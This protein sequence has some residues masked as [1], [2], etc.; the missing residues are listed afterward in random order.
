M[1]T[2]NAKHTGLKWEVIFLFFFRQEPGINHQ[3]LQWR[4]AVYSFRNCCFHE[5][6]LTNGTTSQVCGGQG[7]AKVRPKLRYIH[8]FDLLNS[9]KLWKYL[10]RSSMMNHTFLMRNNSDDNCSC[11][12][13]PQLAAVGWLT[14]NSWRQNYQPQPANTSSKLLTSKYE[15]RKFKA[16]YYIVFRL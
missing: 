5:L 12:I 1:L 2:S 9:V 4:H 16:A 14:S 13:Y 8:A 10:L 3:R 15:H 6:G 11:L 7:G